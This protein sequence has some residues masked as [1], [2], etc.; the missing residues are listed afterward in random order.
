MKNSSQTEK[1]RSFKT[2]TSKKLSLRK[3]LLGW[4]FLLPLVFIMYIMIW[5]PS[6]MGIFWSFF[7]MKGYSVVKFVGLS[8]YID[9]ISDMQ[10]WPTMLNTVQ[11]VLWSLV[12]GFLLPL[13]L[14]VMLNEMRH[15]KSTFRITLYLPAVVP[16]II[17]MLMWY[18][19]YYPDQTGLLNMI[20]AKMGIDPILWLNDSA[21]VIPCIIIS[22]TW[23]GCPGA[24]L[25]YYSALQ[26]VSKELYEAALID[27]AGIFKR[28]WHVTRPQIMGV[29]LLNLIRQII[30]VF[31]IMEQP[32][33]MTQGGPNNAS[34]SIGY[35]LYKYGFV[36]NRAD[37]AMALGVITF[38][39]LI[40]ITAFYF[41]VE[42]K[43]SDN[44]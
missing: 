9:V 40:F 23:N 3:N 16:G 44:Y 24:M 31:Q 17:V 4:A 28:V 30:G 1:Q 22:M 41:R 35:Q 12:I 6:F 8:N 10:F 25:L 20:L 5:R 19:I 27:G 7:R 36:L 21:L 34:L 38:V 39:I 13:I 32:M 15:F 42:K 37:Y 2:L 33:T 29:V 14:A 43:V 26:S 11:Y 18:F